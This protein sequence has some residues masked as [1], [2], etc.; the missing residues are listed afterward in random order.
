MRKFLFVYKWNTSFCSS[1]ISNDFVELDYFQQCD[2]EEWKTKKMLELK[3]E[4]LCILNTIE[5]DV[6]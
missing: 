4:N 1:T 5:I 6:G 2:I 3:A